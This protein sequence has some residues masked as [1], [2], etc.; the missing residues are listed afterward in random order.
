LPDE[1]L[2][3]IAPGVAPLDQPKLVL[4][5]ESLPAADSPAH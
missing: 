4:N 2:F 5:L 1:N 3:H